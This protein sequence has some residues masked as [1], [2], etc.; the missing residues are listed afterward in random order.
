MQLLAFF[1]LCWCEKIPETAMVKSKKKSIS[2]E[3]YLG[4]KVAGMKLTWWQEKAREEWRWKKLKCWNEWSRWK[5][6]VGGK[7]LKLK[8]TLK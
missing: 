7:K 4:E 8:K 2:E 1:F 3:G 6:G 5:E